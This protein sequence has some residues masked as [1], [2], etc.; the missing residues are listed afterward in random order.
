MTPAKLTLWTALVVGVV[1][2]ALAL[3]AGI[4]HNAQREFFDPSTG[5]FDLAYAAL[6]F[7]SWFVPGFLIVA[8]CGAA[9][10]AVSRLAKRFRSNSGATMR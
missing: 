8:A 2:A 9:V 10:I 7:V 3:T 1:V 4:Q 5:S 6:I